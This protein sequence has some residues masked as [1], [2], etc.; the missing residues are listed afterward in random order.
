MMKAILSTLAL[1]ALTISSFGTEVLSNGDFE[2]EG[3]WSHSPNVSLKGE[4]WGIKPASG[5]KMAVLAVHGYD[6]AWLS[7]PVNLAGHH[8]VT[9]SFKYKL[10]AWDWYPG[11]KPDRLTLRLGDYLL[12]EIPMDDPWDGEWLWFFPTL[13]T[14]VETEWLTFRKT[15]PVSAF[16][17][18]LQNLILRFDLKNLDGSG[19][20]TDQMCAAYLDEVSVNTAPEP[21]TIVT[22]GLALLGAAGVL[23]RARRKI[24]RKIDRSP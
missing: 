22:M 4:H 2:G 7:Q 17:D 14:P 8:S 13:G 18:Q 21:A 10:K 1:F 16:G 20:D 19:G 24:G 11:G 3:G 6:D 12:A 5:S 9:I 15:Y 23:R